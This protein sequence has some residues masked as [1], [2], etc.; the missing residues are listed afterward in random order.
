[1]CNSRAVGYLRDYNKN[2][3]LS[4]PVWLIRWAILQRYENNSKSFCDG[5]VVLVEGEGNVFPGS[6]TINPILSI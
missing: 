1:M 5:K 6:N 3:V 4:L 2:H